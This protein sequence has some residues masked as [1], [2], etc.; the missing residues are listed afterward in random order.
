MSSVV[1]GT[2]SHSLRWTGL[3]KAISF[4]RYFAF[5]LPRLTTATG[6]TLLLSTV[7]IR[8]YLL[9]GDFRFPAYFDAYLALIVAISLAA[10]VLMVVPRLRVTRLGW[11]LGTL[12]QV[13]SIAMYLTSHSAGL[14][15]MH[16]LAGR[17]DYPLGT[18]AMG[19]AAMYVA[20]HFSVVT[21]MSI[22]YPDRRNWHD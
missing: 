6:I 3:P 13:P 15:G 21:R 2:L 12:A 9:V 7:A 4:Y 19:L 14:P 10:A 17:W 5:N 16:Q 22:A 11:A 1:A 18:L 20:G 8:L